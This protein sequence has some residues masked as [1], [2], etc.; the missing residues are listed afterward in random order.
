[1]AL[2]SERARV[3]AFLLGAVGVYALIVLIPLLVSVYY[4]FLQWNG[5]GEMNFIG[6]QNYVELFQDRV[7]VKA[8]VNSFLLALYST[9]VQIPI[10]LL[11]ALTLTAKSVRREGIF[12]TVYFIPVLL[13]SVVIGQLWLKIYSPKYGMLNDVLSML[14]ADHLIQSWLGDPEVALGAVFVPILWQYVGYH[15]L[16]LYA[17]L[18]SIPGEI[19]EASR[20]DGANWLQQSLRVR[21][22]MIVPM[23]KVSLI[24]A[25]T[26]SFKF[27]DLIYVMT[28]G[29]PLHATEVP[30]TF[31]Y[32]MI[33]SRTRYGA[34][35]AVAVIIVLECLL[36]TMII[37]RLMRRDREL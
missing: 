11:L 10:S 25:V 4:G 19:E 34:G 27:F 5:Y 8:L 13:S 35:S 30:S 7:F 18:R 24:F 36:F 37:Q 1:M 31:M 6:L 32:T 16:L 29:G 3:P 9:A 26:G 17:A 28:N 22:P 15:M 23:I 20:I 2:Y 33:F 21:I 12:R 14:G